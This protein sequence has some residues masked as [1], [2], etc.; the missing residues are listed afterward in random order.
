LP[1]FATVIVKFVDAKVLRSVVANAVAGV[2][3]TPQITLVPVPDKA[4]ELGLPAA[5]L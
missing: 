4:K 1:L 5:E 2:P 3:V